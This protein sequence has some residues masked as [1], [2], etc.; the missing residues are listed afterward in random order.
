MIPFERRANILRSLDGE[1]E[2][3]RMELHTGR[4]YAAWSMRPTE[5]WVPIHIGNTESSEEAI[6]MCEKNKLY[7]GAV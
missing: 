1:F 2:I 3:V 6:A 5:D 4:R 7:G